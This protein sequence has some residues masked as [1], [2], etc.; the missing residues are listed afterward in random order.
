VTECLLPGQ[1]LVDGLLNESAGHVP[2]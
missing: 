1:D 2:M